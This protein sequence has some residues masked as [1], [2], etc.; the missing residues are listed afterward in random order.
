MDVS[1]IAADVEASLGQLDVGAAA[2]AVAPGP[3]DAPRADGLLEAIAAAQLATM[4]MVG[5]AHRLRCA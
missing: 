5:E 1:G 3:P 4:R 2:P